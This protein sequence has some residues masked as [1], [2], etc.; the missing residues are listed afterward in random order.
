MVLG[1]R[2]G[3]GTGAKSCTS[4]CSLCS[5]CVSRTKELVSAQGY[6]PLSL[7]T[8][9]M[10]C[11]V[12]FPDFICCLQCWGVLD[13]LSPICAFTSSVLLFLK[14]NWKSLFSPISDRKPWFHR[15]VTL[16]VCY[17]FVCL[18]N[19]FLVAAAYRILYC[20]CVRKPPD[21]STQLLLVKLGRK[22][23]VNVS[24]SS[25]FSPRATLLSFGWHLGLSRIT[26]YA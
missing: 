2:K 8:S 10:S 26:G 19:S 14:I 9:V 11:I 12:S 20:C 7:V 5:V 25:E 24:K 16:Q 17:V 13:Q 21:T 1:E 22:T 3:K 6:R 4:L 23:G 15:S 18:S